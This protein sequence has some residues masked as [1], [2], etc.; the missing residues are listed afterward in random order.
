MGLCRSKCLYG[1]EEIVVRYVLILYPNFSEEF[2][3]H[4]DA[5]KPELGIVVRQNG[6]PINFYQHKLTPSQIHDKTT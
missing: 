4:T 1:N 6:K 5:R 2:I 3:I